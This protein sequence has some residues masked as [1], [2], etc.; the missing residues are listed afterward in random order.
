MTKADIDR[1][2]GVTVSLSKFEAR[3]ER[4][5]K[6]YELGADNTV[7][8]TGGTNM[9]K[10]NYETIVIT[11]ADPRCST[12]GDRD[13][14]RGAELP[15]G[16]RPRRRHRHSAPVQ[17]RSSSRNYYEK[18]TRPTRA[19]RERGSRERSLTSSGLRKV[20]GLLL[21]DGD[22]RDNLHETLT[23]LF[24]PFAEGRRVW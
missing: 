18:I 13:Q 24:P 16:D 7:I 15:R 3:G 22:E 23:E 12:G 2:P 8:K 19:R 14:D 6:L 20:S 4:L 11:A 9:G 1:L 10:G 21:L 5:S 17:A